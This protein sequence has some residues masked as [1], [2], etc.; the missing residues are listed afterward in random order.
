MTLLGGMILPVYYLIYSAFSGRYK[1]KPI[2]FFLI[3]GVLLLGL[4]LAFNAASGF[5]LL[6]AASAYVLLDF[7]I[8]IKIGRALD[9]L[10]GFGWLL[11]SASAV[12]ALLYAKVAYVL[13]T[14]YLDVIYLPL[15]LFLTGAGICTFAVRWSDSFTPLMGLF[16][17]AVLFLVNVFLSKVLLEH[18]IEGEAST[19]F[20][21]EIE[22]HIQMN[23]L[24]SHRYISD[25]HAAIDHAELGFLIWSFRESGFIKYKMRTGW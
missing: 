24:S 9:L 14:Q 1:E 19:R 6:Y 11:L 23:I 10:R 17:V 3:A 8:G 5:L 16:F 4:V 20:A 25:N 13:L 12:F 21:K 22:A 2:R 18:Y 7:L 15:L